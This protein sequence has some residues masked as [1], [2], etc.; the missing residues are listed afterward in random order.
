MK[1]FVPLFG[2]GSRHL[3]SYHLSCRHHGFINCAKGSFSQCICEVL[4]SL[5]N[6]PITC[7]MSDSPL[8]ILM[9]FDT[10]FFFLS[11]I[12]QVLFYLFSSK[13]T[14]NVNKVLQGGFS[15]IQWNFIIKGHK[16]HHS[17]S[18]SPLL[19]TY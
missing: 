12:S 13:L 16:K 2:I 5:L 8:Q 6:F 10:S 18:I 1:V 11:K 9:S 15:Y 7:K 17:L 14:C 4:C 3:H 19:N